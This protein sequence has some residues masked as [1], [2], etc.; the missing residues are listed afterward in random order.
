MMCHVGCNPLVLYLM[1]WKRNFIF[2]GYSLS[3][4][5]IP[6]FTFVATSMT[7]KPLNIFLQHFVMTQQNVSTL[8]N[9]IQSV[10]IDD[11]FFEMTIHYI[12]L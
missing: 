7:K 5:P 10:I 12:V 8:N 2:F 9:L 1:T 11:H 3:S 6:I 4:D